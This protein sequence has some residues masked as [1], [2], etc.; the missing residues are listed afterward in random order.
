MMFGLM[1]VGAGLAAWHLLGRSAATAP[2]PAPSDDAPYA[3][4]RFD[5]Q[6]PVLDLGTQPLSFPD[7]MVGVGLQHDDGLRQ[8]LAGQGWTLTPRP[9]RKGADM[10]PFLD[11]RLD[12]AIMGDMPTLT[13]CALHDVVVIGQIKLTSSSVVART[14]RSLA[15]LAGRRIAYGHGSTAHFTLLKGLREAGLADTDVVLVPMEIDQMPAA[16]REGRID[17]FSAWEPAPTIALA[18]D[19]SATV[20]YR[21]LNTAFVL[22]SGK[23]HR[24]HPAI[25]QAVAESLVRTVTGLRRDPAHLATTAAL[26]AQEAQ[27]FTG[28]PSPLDADQAIAI[29]RRELLDPADLPSIPAALLDDDGLLAQEA[30][31]LRQ[32]GRIPADRPWSRL[33]ACFVAGQTKPGTAGP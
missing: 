29:T 12:A 4:Y 9:F 2:L 11:G 27:A 19:P 23:L 7:V 15:D 16:L 13:A 20:V 14:A 26:A 21:G 6:A 30:A 17:A 5:L 25:A 3:G 31:F 24:D 18:A 1:F 22:V 33:K 28:K 8:A 10:L 32:Q